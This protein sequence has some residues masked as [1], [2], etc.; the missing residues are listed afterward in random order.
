MNRL[1]HEAA[2]AYLS[3][4]DISK[5]S[6]MSRGQVRDRMKAAGLNQ[7]DGKRMMADHAAK[8]LRENAELLGVDIDKFDLTSPLAYLPAAVLTALISGFAHH[9]PA[10]RATQ[11]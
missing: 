4:A 11:T 3:V 7:R 6:G 9:P 1:L 5:A 10:L 8:A 2:L